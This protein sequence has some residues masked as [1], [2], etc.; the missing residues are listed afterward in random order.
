MDKIFLF[1]H[2]RLSKLPVPE[3][4]RVEYFDTKQ[5]KLRLRVSS[6]GAMS[7]AVVKKV[8]GKPKRVTIGQWPEISIA[9]AR[10]EAINIL[11]E[12][13]QG[14]D[15]VKEK[16]KKALEST[17]LKDVL[18][19]YLSERGLKLSTEEGYR[20][21][22]RSSFENWLDKPVHE[23]TERMVLKRH[24]ELSKVGKTTANTAM[25]VLRLTMNYADATGMIESPPTAILSKARLW[26]KPNRKDRVIPSNKLKDWHDAVDALTNE[27]AKVYL[28]LVLY[29]G[30]RSSEA[31]K[32]EWENVDLEAKSI[33][34]YDT[35]N[36]TNH[37]LPIPLP[38]LSY[39]ESLKELTGHSE[40]VFL[41]ADSPNDDFSKKPMSVPKRS[42]AT[43]IKCS[44]VEFSPH[45]CRRTFATIAEAV[46][47]PLT[48]IK[49]LMNHVTT[50]EVTGG[51]IVTEEET[52]RVAI[53]NVANYIQARVTQKDNV[54]DIQAKNQINN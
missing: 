53:N 3:T 26:H 52:L 8:N 5:Q 24:K 23:I 50:N 48:M 32:L 29:M 10:D 39:L 43:V 11:D 47:L 27:K 20:Y 19:M 14:V 28:L 31:L 38:L 25:R 4:G 1:T 22:L 41:G 35:K 30:Y 33:T 21:K 40:W 51:Y 45:D 13:R 9:K 18:E 7:F 17:K 36:G 2:E 15:P 54:I 6:S 12:L 37:A 49:R 42:I 16:R 44:G 46:N 34:L